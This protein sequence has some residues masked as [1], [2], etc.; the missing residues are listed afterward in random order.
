MRRPAPGRE[1]RARGTAWHRPPGSAGVSPTPARRRLAVWALVALAARASSDGLAFAVAGGG[2]L[3]SA[4]R[5]AAVADARR[6]GGEGEEPQESI[7]G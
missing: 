5:G 2:P 6:I 1:Q 4:R 3:R 7:P